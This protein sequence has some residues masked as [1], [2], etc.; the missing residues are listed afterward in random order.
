MVKVEDGIEWK[1]WNAKPFV[2]VKHATESEP[3]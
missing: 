2:E 3:T 1:E